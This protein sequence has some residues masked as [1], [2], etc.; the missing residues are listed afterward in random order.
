MLISWKDR[1][2]ERD[3]KARALHAPAA[4]V[5]AAP[6]SKKAKGEGRSGKEALMPLVRELA[7]SGSCINWN[8]ALELLEL[9]G[10]DSTVLRIWGT[11]SDKCEIDRMCM[12]ART[13]LQK[14]GR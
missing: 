3:A 2:P 6:R 11:A 12:R 9:Q 5:E 10:T 14:H 8:Q 4:T 13:A 7:Q 1:H